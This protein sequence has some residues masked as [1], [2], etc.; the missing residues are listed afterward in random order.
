MADIDTVNTI[1]ASALD[2]VSTRSP[3][4]FN[5]INRTEL[6]ERMQQ[7]FADTIPSE[8]TINSDT[9]DFAGI[10]LQ[11]VQELQDSAAWADTSQTAVGQT[12]LRNIA[13]GFSHLQF[14]LL[15]ANQNAFMT[16]GSSKETIYAAMNFLGVNIRRKVPA[17]LK[18]KFSIA[19]HSG[20]FT[21]PAFTPFTIS[22]VPFFNRTDII[23]TEYETT[24]IIELVQG[25]L[26]SMEGEAAGISYEKVDIGYENYNISNDDVYVFVNDEMWAKST[27]LKPWDLGKRDKIFI[28]KTLD[29]GNVAIQFGN[30]IYGKRLSEGDAIKII[31]A[32]VLGSETPSI[33]TGSTFLI[34]SLELDVTGEVI[35]GIYGFDDELSIDF[36]QNLGPTVRSSNEVAVTRPSHITVALQ[37]PK[38]RDAIFRGQA[39]IAPN[40]RNWINI[41]EA[42]VL[43]ADG[44]VLS[45]DSWDDFVKYMESR[46]IERLTYLRKD[47][48]IIPVNI[49]ADVNCVENSDLSVIKPKLIK[50]VRDFNEVKQGS[51]GYSL[52]ESDISTLLEGDLL[53]ATLKEQISFVSNVVLTYADGFDST[54]LGS[55]RGIVNKDIIADFLD[56]IKFENINLSMKYTTR[57][58]LQRRDLTVGSIG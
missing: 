29:T 43:S 17:K 16:S 9:V 53:N 28:A 27:T 41:C 39:E 19:D 49:S 2:Y 54:I 44:T 11:F 14:A 42:T 24:K 25:Q 56:F 20:P 58:V 30:D 10:L 37:Y 45:D 33:S 5:Y 57:R 31:W 36:Y 18:V 13:A 40:K 35:G 52:Y 55:S 8:F 26:F 23:Y 34:Q 6:E 7:A 22:S 46:S 1:I 12:V 51:I 50:S 3:V 32:E 15:R 48:T 47:P 4:F 38:I 21:I